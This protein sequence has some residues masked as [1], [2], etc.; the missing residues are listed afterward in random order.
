MLSIAKCRIA[1]AFCLRLLRAQ[2]AASIRPTTL[3]LTLRFSS[4]YSG[5]GLRC[6]QAAAV[7]VNVDQRASS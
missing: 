3:L 7:V 2:A 6:A 4:G 5:S 1:S